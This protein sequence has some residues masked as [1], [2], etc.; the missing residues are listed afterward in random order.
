MTRYFRFGEFEIVRDP[1]TLPRF[2]AVCVS[3]LGNC[4]A[5]SGNLPDE[6]TMHRWIGEH[7][8]DTGHYDFDRNMGDRCHV[9]PPEGAIIAGEVVRERPTLERARAH[10]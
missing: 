10:P 7:A 6:G 4:H 3:D 2:G 5:H 1:D 8:R 9:I